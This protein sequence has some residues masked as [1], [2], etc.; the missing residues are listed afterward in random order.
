MDNCDAIQKLTANITYDCSP[1][2][3]AKA[4]LETTAVLINR[5]DI[6]LTALTQSG[7]TVTNLSLVSGATGYSIGW[8]KNLANTASEFTAND[9][10]LD[11]F[12]QSFAC[13]VFGQSAADVERINELKSGEFVAV[14]ETKYKGASNEAAYKVFGLEN[15][16]KMNEG[17]FTSL[18]NDGS[19][20]FTIG[21]QEG[22]GETYV[23]QIW[24]EGSYASNKAKFDSNFAG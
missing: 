2:G 13:R 19:F 17:T 7:A 20:L 5:K 23:Y 10:G 22:F 3:R 9:S 14:V 16:L 1:S 6:D 12:T 24:N 4:G 8:I 11:S 15:G 18:E 21:S